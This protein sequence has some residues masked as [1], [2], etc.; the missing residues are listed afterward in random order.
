[1]SKFHVGDRVTKTMGV[2]LNGTIVD[3]F[4]Y[5]DSTDGTYSPPKADYVPVEWDDGTKGYCYEGHLD[6]EY[7]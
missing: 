4:Y 5:K 1:M 2:R 3:G 7:L 6:Y